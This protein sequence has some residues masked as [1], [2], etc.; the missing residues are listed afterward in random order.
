MRVDFEGGEMTSEA[1]LLLLRGVDEELQFTERVNELV[2]D[3]RD[4]DKVEHEQIALLRQ[5]VYQ[6]IAGYEDCK[7]A[8]YL[9][10]D[11]TLK[12]V[13]QGETEPEVLASQPTLSRLENRIS[14]RE[15][16][17]LNHLLSETFV[18][19]SLPRIKQGEPVI[20]DLDGTD[21]PAHGQQQLVLFNGFYG[22]YMYHPLLIFEGHQKDLLSV[23][24]RTGKCDSAAGVVTILRPLVSRL[25]AVRRKKRKQTSGSAANSPSSILLRGDA[26]F[27]TPK[28]YDFCEAHQLQ[29]CLGLPANPVLQRKAQPLLDKV[30]A[31]DEKEGEPQREY[32]SFQ[33]RAKG[34]VRSRR[35]VVKVEVNAQGTN[36][37]FVVTNRKGSAESVYAF[38]AERGEAENGIKELKRGFQGDRLSCHR[39]AANAFRL[40]LHSLAY[41]L[42]HHWRQRTLQKTIYANAQISTL[43]RKLIKVGARVVTTARRV[44]FHLPTGYQYREAW[45]RQAQRLPCWEVP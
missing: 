2:T 14:G 21:D 10:R 13:C 24:L 25:Q 43:R 30:V 40:L 9:R 12:V 32:T 39:F 38:Y 4:P 44:W 20:L 17:E 5:R 23:T 11:P 1:G 8:D 16:R 29:Y 15:I 35:V 3:P 22:Q 36:Q 34:W 26:G 18:K 41:T 6:I 33:Y 37:R 27:A 45:F 42:V 28:L 7:D 19:H 31:K